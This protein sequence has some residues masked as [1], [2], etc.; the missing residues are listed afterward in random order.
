MPTVQINLWGV[1][2]AAAFAMVIGALWYSDLLFGRQWGKLVGKKREAM[3]KRAGQAYLLTAILWLLAG[4]VLAIMVQVVAAD[5]WMEGAVTAFYLWT[6]FVFSVGLIHTLF[7]GRS[8]RL[9]AIN[10][11]YTLISLLGMGIILV[12]LPN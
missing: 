9:F 8:K 10:A 12:L 5:Q 1:I 3:M 4:Y 11:G 2:A 7:D 6:G